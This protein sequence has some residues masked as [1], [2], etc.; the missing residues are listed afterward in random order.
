MVRCRLECHR[1]GKATSVSVLFIRAGCRSGRFIPLDGIGDDTS[2]EGERHE[3]GGSEYASLLLFI[4]KI[5][6]HYE[7]GEARRRII[8]TGLKV[9]PRSAIVE[10]GRSVPYVCC[11]AARQGHAR[12]FSRLGA[13][14]QGRM[15][16][17]RPWQG[18]RVP[19]GRWLPPSTA[20]SPT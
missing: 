11:R 17:R 19:R 18:A 9:G 1:R 7:K 16:T 20:L 14:V 2:K 5:K 13:P 8:R 15:G 6:T 12:R 4:D 10:R 3:E